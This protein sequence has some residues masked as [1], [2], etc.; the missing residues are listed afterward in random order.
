MEWSSDGIDLERVRA[1]DRKHSESG[2]EADRSR[3]PYWA[4]TGR[5][6]WAER[7]DA[8][9]CLRQSDADARVSDPVGVPPDRP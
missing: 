4:A 8:P 1:N 2:A 9:D 6:Y 5:S 3:R 7:D